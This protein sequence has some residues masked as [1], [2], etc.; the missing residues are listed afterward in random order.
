MLMY[1]AVIFHINNIQQSMKK[2]DKYNIQH[3]F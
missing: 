1:F 3:S 2:M